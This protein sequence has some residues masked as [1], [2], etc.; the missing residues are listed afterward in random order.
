M[1]STGITSFA[2]LD[3]R[4]GSY[5]LLDIHEEWSY[6]ASTLAFIGE[7]ES[8]TSELFQWCAQVCA[9]GKCRFDLLLYA[10]GKLV[11]GE[12]ADHGATADGKELLEQASGA[13]LSS[14]HGPEQHMQLA[15]VRMF[16]RS[17]LDRS[18]MVSLGKLRAEEVTD[19]IGP[20]SITGEVAH[21]STIDEI[22]LFVRMYKQLRAPLCGMLP[23][24]QST[25]FA[26][27]F[28]SARASPRA[29][30]ALARCAYICCALAVFLQVCTSGAWVPIVCS[31]L[32][33]ETPCWQAS[34]ICSR[35]GAP[36]GN[37]HADAGHSRYT[38]NGEST[39]A[40]PAV[41]VFVPLVA[42]TKPQARNGYA[43][44][45]FCEGW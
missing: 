30:Q 3:K 29:T 44:R 16:G 12:T 36:A 31:A 34:V 41:C 27:S 15:H 4:E 14:G 10:D 42:L 17:C 40:P 24:M 45:P 7:R 39:P 23:P 35:A 13:P 38:F 25:T 9:R 18:C 43:R 5:L 20:I 2:S 22:H 11:G 32:G 19:P 21:D 8:T 28:V 33:V 37:W 1:R 6:C 26:F